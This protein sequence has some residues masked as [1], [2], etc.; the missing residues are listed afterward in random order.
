MK[1]PQGTSS[2]RGKRDRETRR[3]QR[4]HLTTAE[5]LG[6]LSANG[7][8][9]SLNIRRKHIQKST[10]KTTD[11]SISRNLQLV[12][13]GNAGEGRG[14]KAQQ[15]TGRNQYIED[16]VRFEKVPTLF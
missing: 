16:W 3:A 4:E 12:Q 14:K 11:H 13:A 2:I 1:K 7:Q 8:K 10:K 6:K 9:K 15:D 5:G